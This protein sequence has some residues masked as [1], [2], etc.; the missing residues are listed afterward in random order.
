[1]PKCPFCKTEINHPI[2]EWNYRH[3]YYRVKSFVCQHCGLKFNGYYHDSRFSHTIP[4]SPS[5]EEKIKKFLNA[6][7]KVKSKEIANKL[8][9][10]SKEVRAVLTKWKEEEDKRYAA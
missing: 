7:P 2:A 4:K 8:N 10:N 6:N 9:L 1:M 3:K 5:V